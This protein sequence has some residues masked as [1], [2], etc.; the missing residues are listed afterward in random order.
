MS[1]EAHNGNLKQ[2]EMVDGVHYLFPHH[3]ANRLDAQIRAGNDGPQIQLLRRE[4][5]SWVK[6]GRP[7]LDTNQPGELVRSPS[8]LP[9]WDRAKVRQIVQSWQHSSRGW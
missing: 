4:V 2:E 7:L 6:A 8:N 9:L 5:E 3:G 1:C